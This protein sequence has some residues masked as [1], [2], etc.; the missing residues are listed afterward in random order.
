MDELLERI[1]KKFGGLGVM[2]VMSMVVLVLAIVLS[3]V[4]F[5]APYLLLILPTIAAWMVWSVWN[6]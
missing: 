5:F 1:E 2:L 3:M 4:V 6:D